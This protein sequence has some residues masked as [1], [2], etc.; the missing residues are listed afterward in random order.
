MRKTFRKAISQEY[1]III[2]L[3]TDYER[4]IEKRTMY[5]LLAELVRLL[6]II[7]SSLVRNKVITFFLSLLTDTLCSQQ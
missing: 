6:L 2:T 3:Y 5:V 7:V 4:L 1:E